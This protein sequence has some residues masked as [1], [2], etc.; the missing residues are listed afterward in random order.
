MLPRVGG[1]VDLAHRSQY[2]SLDPGLAAAADDTPSPVSILREP[3]S[4]GECPP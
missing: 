4:L 1:D 2:L 3:Q